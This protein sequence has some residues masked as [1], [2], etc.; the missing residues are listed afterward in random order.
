[1]KNVSGPNLAQKKQL[2][3]AVGFT[4]AGQRNLGRVMVI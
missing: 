2:R 3:E 1:M 4:K